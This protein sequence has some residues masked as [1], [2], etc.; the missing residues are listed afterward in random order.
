ML[1]TK[2][3]DIKFLDFDKFL[4]ISNI[5]M[6]KNN[7]IDLDDLC[8]VRYI[9]EEEEQKNKVNF[10][11]KVSEALKDALDSSDEEEMKTKNKQMKKIED[12]IIS[13]KDTLGPREKNNNLEN[14][15]NNEIIEKDLINENINDINSIKNNENNEKV[16][17][18]IFTFKN[19]NIIND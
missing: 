19:E 5:K 4:D 1:K 13:G 6:D 17:S 7:K 3:T 8:N 18:N 11:K 10:N 12:I 15:I 9:T 16:D 14:I 2:N